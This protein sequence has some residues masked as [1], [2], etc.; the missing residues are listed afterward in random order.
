M[1]NAGV[2][3]FVSAKQ[4][5]HPFGGFFVGLFG[6]LL[7]PPNS[8]RKESIAPLNALTS[9]TFRSSSRLALAVLLLVVLGVYLP[10][11]SDVLVFDNAIIGG[12]QLFAEYGNPFALKPRAL[13]YGTIVWIQKLAGDAWWLQRLINV[14]LHMAVVVMLHVFYR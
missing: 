2:A 12:G 14:L 6:L 8:H 4:S 5:G 10:S 1:A 11:L 3:A 9:V 7:S 13:S